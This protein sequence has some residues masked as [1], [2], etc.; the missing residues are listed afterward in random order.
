M[1]RK[2]QRYP[3][4]LNTNNERKIVL[5]HQIKPKTIGQEF[6]IDAVSESV[7]TLC[8]GPAGCGK[9]YLTAGI[10]LEK[11]LNNDV[12]QITVTKPI[13]EAGGESIGFLKG[14]EEEKIAPHFQNIL[15]A[16]EDHIGPTMVK[17][18][19]TEERIKFIPIGFMR[20]RDLKNSFIFVDEAQ[21]LTKIGI[22][23]IMTRISYGSQI[24]LSGDT[25]QVDIDLRKSGLRWA[26]DNLVGKHADIAV[27]KMHASDVC[28]HPLITTLVNN[29]ILEK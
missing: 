8:E 20:G 13:I 5:K 27:V 2:R 16:F 1:T 18:L 11:L 10:A 29:L 26:I 3:Q 21:N 24:V 14:S 23:L 22:K 25:D 15:D 4:E 7:I 19:I 17:K 9:T 28:R 12:N 6:F